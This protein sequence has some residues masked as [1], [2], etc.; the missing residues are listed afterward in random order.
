MG[1]S[2][3]DIEKRINTYYK[4]VIVRHPLERIL[5]AYRHLFEEREDNKIVSVKR[6]GVFNNI[7]R[8][9]LTFSLEKMSPVYG[10]C[11]LYRERYV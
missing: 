9:R 3:A 4:F 11:Y 2:R 8:N 5:S 7:S 6:F 1:Y 10:Y